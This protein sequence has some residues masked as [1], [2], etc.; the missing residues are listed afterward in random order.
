MIITISG[1]AGSGKSSVAKELSQRLGLKH[2]SIGDVMRAMAQEK[3][4]T[5]LELNTL[6]EKDPAIDKELD[7]RLVN[8]G[9][10]EQDFVIDGRLT[11]YFIP[12]AD[13][14]I[15]L[16]APVQTRATRILLAQRKDELHASLKE[17][18]ANIEKR[19]ESE[20]KRYRTYYRVDYANKKYYSHIIDTEPLNLQGVVD[21]IVSI[22]KKS[23]A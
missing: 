12:H 9:K 22:V 5:L 20:K 7:D 6:A 18:I 3:G 13:F 16:D 15:F 2:Y 4:M 11:A 19:E 21:A 10:S 23:K 8:L 17:T 14:K 1:K